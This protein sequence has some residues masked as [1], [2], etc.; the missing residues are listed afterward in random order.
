MIRGDSNL[1]VDMRFTHFYVHECL[2][3]YTY[4]HHACVMLMEVRREHWIP[5]IGVTNDCE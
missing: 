1:S 3:T 5:V 4:M 2:S